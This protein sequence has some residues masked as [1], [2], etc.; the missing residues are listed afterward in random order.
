M[1]RPSTTDA[2]SGLYESGW[3]ASSA[4]AAVSIVTTALSKRVST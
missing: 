4:P 1:K 3:E 2:G